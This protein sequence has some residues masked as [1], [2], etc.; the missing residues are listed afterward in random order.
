MPFG[1][2]IDSMSKSTEKKIV[3]CV[4]PDNFSRQYVS[5]TFI[6]LRFVH[7]LNIAATSGLVILPGIQRLF[8]KFKEVSDILLVMN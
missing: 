1:K 2:N 4:V 6:S 7:R 5:Y 3:H 8:V